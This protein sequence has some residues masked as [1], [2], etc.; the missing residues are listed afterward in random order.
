MLE[1]LVLLLALTAEQPGGTSQQQERL[2]TCCHLLSMSLNSPS[3]PMD[4]FRYPYSLL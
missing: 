3:G 2:V 1:L 4:N